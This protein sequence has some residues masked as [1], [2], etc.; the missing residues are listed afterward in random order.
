M[1][2]RKLVTLRRIDDL[3]PIEGADAI[4][5]AVIGGWN[6]VVKKGEFRVG[7]PCVYFEIDSFLPESDP[8]F[9]FL[10]KG[11]VREQDGVRGHRLRTVKLRGQLSQGL[12][13]PVS[14]FPEL[15]TLFGPPLLDYSEL[16]G[17]TKWDPP[18]PAQLAGQVKG[19]FPSFIRKTDQERAQ[20][21][22]REIFA[23]PDKQYEVTTKL[24]GTSVTIYHYNG[25]VGVCSRNLEL[26]LEDDSSTLVKL[27]KESGLLDV[28]RSLGSNIAV[29]GELMGPGIQG[30]REKLKRPELF[31][32]DI[33]QIDQANYLPPLVRHELVRSMLPDL[34]AVRHVPVVH[35]T[36]AL[37]TVAK[38]VGGLLAAAEGPSLAHE[39][40]EGIVFKALDGSFSFKVIS[41]KFLLKEK[42]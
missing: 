27:A 35:P 18:V 4:E 32:F 24:D 11:G 5:C 10:M 26:K 13:L 8:R 25:E 15:Q 9:A 36:V 30:N 3:R 33:F 34:V 21:L 37:S 19:M 23:E 16:F 42:D 1:S 17:V 20:N 41:N 2:E 38:D 29:Q 22:V 14:S 6:V 28:L 12:A 7:D 40:R 39:E 31:I